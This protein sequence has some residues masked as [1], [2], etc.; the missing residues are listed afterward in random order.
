MKCPNCGDE[1]HRVVDSRTTT[2]KGEMFG[3]DGASVT[4]RRRQC[5]CGFRFSTVELY[6]EDAGGLFGPG[7]VDNKAAHDVVRAARHDAARKIM[8]TLMKEME[9]W[10]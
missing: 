2:L 3:P 8:D 6:N 5:P 4:R 9:K 7:G 1:G 10:K